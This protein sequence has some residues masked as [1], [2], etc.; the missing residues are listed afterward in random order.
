MQGKLDIK[1]SVGASVTV[2]VCVGVCLLCD[3]LAISP[4]GFLSCGPRH[5]AIQ[6]ISSLENGWVF[7][8]HFISM[9]KNQLL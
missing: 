6:R 2:N 9:L 4:G 8:L 7:I 5:A 1:S 3:G